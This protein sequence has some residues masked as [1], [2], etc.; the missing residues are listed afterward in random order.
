MSPD[1]NGPVAVKFVAVV[2]YSGLAPESVL[3]S[4]M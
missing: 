4:Y 1:V 3:N 2:A